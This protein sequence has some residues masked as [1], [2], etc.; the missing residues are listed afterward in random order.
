MAP[1]LAVYALKF[2]GMVTPRYGYAFHNTGSLGW[3]V[4]SPHKRSL[5]RG[6]LPCRDLFFIFVL[7]NTY[8]R[9]HRPTCCS[10]RIGRASF[11]GRCHCADYTTG[12]ASQDQCCKEKT[13]IFICEDEIRYV[14]LAA[15]IW[16]TLLS[17]YFLY[18]L[19][20]H[21]M[22][23]FSAWLAICAG[24]SPAIGEFPAQRPVTRSFDVFCNL[25]LNKRL[26]KQ[27]WR[28][29]CETPSS[30]LWCHCNDNLSPCNSLK[31]LSS[32]LCAYTATASFT[33]AHNHCYTERT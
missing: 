16:T 18:T 23:T 21:Q 31:C 4:D 8:G 9:G 19:W 29:W 12:A 28:C 25:L 26:R 33:H 27:S 10:L 6:A 20:R 24:N 2:V 30:P 32:L 3:S 1:I 11:G 22:V 5:M 15:I 17:W 14:A 13:H 7:W